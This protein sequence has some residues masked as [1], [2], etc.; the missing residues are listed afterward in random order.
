MCGKDSIA[1]TIIEIKSCFFQIERH[2]SKAS[3]YALKKQYFENNEVVIK[4][5]MDNG[6][7]SKEG[8]DKKLTE[9]N[10]QKIKFSLLAT[11]SQGTAISFLQSSYAKIEKNISF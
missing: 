10:Q 2:T 5:E 11:Q 6:L 7:I 9:N 8:A 1:S 3:N 4:K